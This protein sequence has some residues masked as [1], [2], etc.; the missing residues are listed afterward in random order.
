MLKKLR[1]I[2]NKNLPFLLHKSN[3][4]GT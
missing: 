2:D 4:N 3:L 1:W